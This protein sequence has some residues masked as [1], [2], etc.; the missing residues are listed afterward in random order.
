MKFEFNTRDYQEIAIQS[1]IDLFEGQPTKQQ[2]LDNSFSKTPIALGN[3][4]KISKDKLKENLY[5]VQKQNHRKEAP[6]ETSENLNE[7][8]YSIEMETGTGKTF[9]YL[10]TIVELAKKYDWNKYIVVVP[11]VAIREGV[12]TELDR[13]KPKFESD[14]KLSISMT[15]YDSKNMNELETFHDSSMLE[16]MLMTMQSFNSDSNNLHKEYKDLPIVKPIKWIQN[17]NPIV[18]LDEPQNIGEA[19]SNKLQEFNPLFTLRYSATHKKLVNLIYRYTPID[20]YNDDYVKKIEVLSVF[21]DESRDV[22]SYV[23]VLKIDNDKNGLFARVKFYKYESNGVKV[24]S[25]KL[26]HGR[27]LYEDSGNMPE[28]KGYKINEINLTNKFIQ[29]DNGIKVNENDV[30]QDKDELMK[31]QI[32]ETIRTHL[33]KEKELKKDGIKVLSLFFIDKVKNYRDYSDENGK[34]KIRKWFEE[35]Y[36]KITGEPEYQEFSVENMHN[37]EKIEDIQGAYFSQDKKNNEFKDSTNRTT[38]ADEETYDLIMRNK[39][40]LLSFEHPVRFIFSHSALREGWDNPNVFQI[41]TLNETTSEMKKR[42]EIG[43]GLRLPVNQTG[44]RI[45]D[46]HINILTVVANQSYEIFAKSLQNEITE[47]TGIETYKVPVENARERQH[48]D[49]NKQA[50]LNPEFQKIWDKISTKTNY[51]IKMEDERLINQIV[52]RLNKEDFKVESVKYQII[53][54]QMD[55]YINASEEGTVH[56]SR[57]EKV[58]KRIRI[59]NVIKRIADNTGLTKKNLIEIIKR[60]GIQNEIFVNPEQFIDKLISIIQLELPKL[61]TKGIKY[62]ETGDK[63]DVSLFKERI[64]V[65]KNSELNSS[66]LF[67][68]DEEPRTLYNV[69]QLDSKN[70]VKLI[71]QFRMDPTRF[72]FFFKLPNWFKVNTPAGNYNPDWAL[73]Y[74]ESDGEKLYLVRESKKTDSPY[75]YSESLYDEEN[76]KIEFGKKHFDAINFDYQVIEDVRDVKNGVYSFG[77]KENTESIEKQ[78]FINGLKAAKNFGLT[79]EQAYT[80]QQEEFEKFDIVREDFEDL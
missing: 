68:E 52:E 8:D 45:Q 77:G 57:T 62:V 76:L 9:V 20:A 7:L 13:L 58:K 46:Q 80:A 32:N 61:L 78:E 59:P 22:E 50:L 6:I 65:Y 23:E 47:D 55:S 54:T 21:G 15:V 12:K 43:R 48:I 74:Q 10:K 26:R 73:V 66:P 42:Q 1:V 39:E 51:S 75:F 30:A 37:V 2:K 71:N 72:K 28:Y 29:F 41:C 3:E 34:G 19:T 40:K 70:E 36:S 31:I 4:L 17:V 33:Y 79:F 44:E 27:D 5:R 24:V 18:I 14:N 64:E 16:I 60:A 25:R 67:R 53:R 69:V 49:L 38:K 35:E 63:Y 56:H 11:S